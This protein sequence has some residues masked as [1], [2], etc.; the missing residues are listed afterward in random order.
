MIQHINCNDFVNAFGR[1]TDSYNDYF[2]YEGKRALFSYLEALEI[3]QKQQIALDVI[4]LCCEFTEYENMGQ[5]LQDYSHLIDE[6]E[7]VEDI[8]NYTTVINVAEYALNT[9]ARFIIRQF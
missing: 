3:D 7:T 5:F 2:S 6:V 1:F 9:N 4:A 8:E